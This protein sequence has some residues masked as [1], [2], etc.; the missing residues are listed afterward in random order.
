MW[1]EYIKNN[2]IKII[3]NHPELYYNRKNRGWKGWKDFFNK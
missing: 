3:P 2:T 1:K